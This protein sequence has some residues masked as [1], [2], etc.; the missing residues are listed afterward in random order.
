MQQT[1]VIA[2]INNGN[3]SFIAGKFMVKQRPLIIF[4]GI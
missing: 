4:P 2:I 1:K 3:R